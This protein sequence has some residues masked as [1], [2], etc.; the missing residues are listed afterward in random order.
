M[1]NWI[2]ISLRNAEDLEIPGCLKI[3]EATKSMTRYGVD[4]G[5][6]L[7]AG[8]SVSEWD[9]LYRALFVYSTGFNGIINDVLRIARNKYAVASS[10]WKVYAILLEYSWH[11]DYAMIIHQL[12]KEGEDDNKQLS[13]EYESQINKLWTDNTKLQNAAD[14]MVG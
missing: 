8:L 5:S 14:E 13:K 9:R 3:A 4:R 10:L 7:Q 12:A 11:V 1:E 6:L 2:D